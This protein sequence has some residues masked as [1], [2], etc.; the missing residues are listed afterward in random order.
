[1]K[2]KLSHHILSSKQLSY[3]FFHSGGIS[4]DWAGV[5]RKYFEGADQGKQRCACV[6]LGSKIYE[7]NEAKFREYDGCPKLSE[8]CTI[9]TVND[10]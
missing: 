8:S 7:E 5:P 2:K 1:M 3:P 4:R 6:N 9:A 10:N